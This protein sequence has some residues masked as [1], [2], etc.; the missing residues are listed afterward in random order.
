MLY[1]GTIP[2]HFA[3]DHA[4]IAEKLHQ[5]PLNPWVAPDTLR[6]LSIP[7]AVQNVL[8][9]VPFGVLGMLAGGLR[10]IRPSRL[11]LVTALGAL[12]SL[13]VEVLQ[14]F[15]ADRVTSVADLM[16]NTTG[17]FAG[18]MLALAGQGVA[19]ST[20]RRLQA[21]GLA[22]AR[23][24]RPLAIWSIV[25][26][27]AAW[28][29][30]DVTL[31]MG[32]VATKVRSLQAGLWQYTG[33]RDEGLILMVTALFAMS[34]AAYLSA[35]G[36]RGSGRK[37]AG[38]AACVVVALE[39]SQILITSRMPTLWDAAVGTA[40]VTAGAMLWSLSRR[41][42]WRGLG[43]SLLAICTAVSAAMAMLSPFETSPEYHT[44]GWFPLLSYYSRTTFE[45]VSHVIELMLLYFPL[46]YWFTTGAPLQ[47]K[48]VVLAIGLALAIAAPVEALQGWVIGRY[49]DIS[50]VALSLAGVWLGVQAAKTDS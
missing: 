2:F 13:T 5:L 20:L 34:L 47:R 33:L 36:V 11:A 6:R 35:V 9:F 32:T 16:T 50:D 42:Q 7:D 22:N 14:L 48:S 10:T 40:G 41:V 19:V 4:A 44:M 25:L 12:L 45:A 31:E 23:E 18:A 46:G 39:G 38:V 29:P 8:F 24:L 27:V 30:F 15:E 37:A 26:V 3:G 28:Q 43:L 1:G 17:A 49:P 21:A